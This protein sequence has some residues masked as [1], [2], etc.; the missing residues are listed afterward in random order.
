[1]YEIIKRTI[2]NGRFNLTE[3]I[4]KINKLWIEETLTEEEKDNLIELAQGNA[5]SK[6]SIDIMQKLIELEKRILSLENNDETTEI[7]D[8]FVVGKWYYTGNKVSFEGK[9]YECIAPIG[10]A[11]VWSPIDYP[12]YWKEI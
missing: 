7:I 2:E 1:M 3:I 10:V 5:N 9:N 4:A 8:E 11:C 12:S 6:N